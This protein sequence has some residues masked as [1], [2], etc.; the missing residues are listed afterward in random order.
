MNDTWNGGPLSEG[1]NDFIDGIARLVE[2]GERQYGVANVGYTEY[3]VERLEICI[4]SCIDLKDCT[5]G[6]SGL[7]S[8][9]ATLNELIEC[10]RAVHRKWLEYEDS[11]E[12]LSVRSLSYQ[13]PSFHSRTGPGRPP[14][15]ISKDQLVYLISMGFKW[16]EIAAMLNVSRMTIY[17]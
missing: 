15:Y 5:E 12:S 1:L 11:I 2:D 16:V 13:A 4:L 6:R 3:F 17:R 10:L 9:C 8:Y 14:F 7:E